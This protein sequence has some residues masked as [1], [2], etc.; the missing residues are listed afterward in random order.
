VH[1]YRAAARRI[2]AVAKAEFGALLAKARNEPPRE[3]RPARKKLVRSR[4]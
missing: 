1:R 4:S 2:D 3:G